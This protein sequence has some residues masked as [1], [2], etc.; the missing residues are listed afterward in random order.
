MSALEDEIRK[1]A[2]QNA[3]FFKGKAN[4]KA[5]VGK[6]LGT[7][8]ECRADVAGTT[9]MINAI[10]EDVNSMDP[11]AQK[12]ALEEI[13]PSMLKKEKKERVYEL[14]ELDNV[15]QGKTVM[16]IA[17]GP[18]G[19][20]HIGH[21]RVSV[22]NDE[23]TKR[24][25]GQLVLRFEDTNPEKIDPDAYDM[26]P[27]DLDWLGV[28]IHQKFIQSERF[29]TYYDITRRL[30]EEGHAYVCT[31]DPDDWRAKKERKEACPCRNLP[32]NE[33][34]ERFDRMMEGG[35]EPGKAIA[36]VKTA[37]DH[38]NP[39]V[40]DFVA[41]RIV[42]APHPRTGSKYRVYPMMNLSVAIDDHLMGMTH[43]IR[44]KD[45]LNNTERQKYIF[46]YMGWK[47]PT[48][49]HYGLVNIPDTVL[50]TSLIKQS[51]KAGEY[52]GWDDVRTGTV[53]ALE[54]RGIRP[55]AIRRYW[56]ESGIK[57]VDIEFS[58][59]NLYGMNRN[60]IDPGSDRYFFV[61]DPVRYDISGTDVIEGKAPLH[62]DNADKGF[63]EYRLEG[64]KTVFL[65]E[66]DSS[67][68]AQERKVRLKDLCNLDYNTPA[69]F[70]GYDVKKGGMKAVQWV[71][72]DSTPCK[73]YMPDGSIAE[74]LV[75]NAILKE[76]ADT[77][78]F[79]RFG[80]VRIEKKD[81]SQITAVYTHD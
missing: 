43:V 31:C 35:Y 9:E 50:K 80:F 13:D 44:G 72:R 22:L 54:R 24:Y 78:Q 74:G 14:P 15:E 19:P 10:V 68:F 26:I 57:S 28:R 64:P 17:P 58:W 38:P 77:V 4:P 33:Q 71:S 34:M 1:F 49:Y 32:V 47:M 40:R 59:D 18:S 52:T 37:I 56:V 21:T 42:D 3:V 41:L 46:G 69:I 2:L 36:V 25:E 20:L 73:V 55:E 65:S 23:Y 48:Y 6:I 5:I 66:K 70:A 29:E 62:P 7:H 30:I 45:H 11:E 53:R 39:A 76:K 60:I 16:R 67:L 12:K 75:E 79:E 63:R 51:I 61:Q 27:E 81:P 8:P